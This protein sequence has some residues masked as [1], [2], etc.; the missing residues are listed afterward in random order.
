MGEGRELGGSALGCQGNVDCVCVDPNLSGTA[1]TAVSTVFGG[2][3]R[4][5]SLALDK[6]VRGLFSLVIYV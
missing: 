6:R 5:F 1:A 3:P 2:S 4:S